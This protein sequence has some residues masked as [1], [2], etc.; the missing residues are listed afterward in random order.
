MVYVGSDDHYVY[1]LNAATGAYI[2]SYKTGGS[3]D[4][5]PAVANGIVYIGSEDHKV[6]A[7]NAAT[8]IKNGATAQV[9]RWSLLLQL[10]TAW[11]TLALTTTR[12]TL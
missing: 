6:Y 1:A 10:P 4:S 8:G 12:F 11:S 5:S 9:T 2:W 7:L 3:I